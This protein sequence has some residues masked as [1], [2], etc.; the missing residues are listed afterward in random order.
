MNHDSPR[1]V[2]E[3][4]ASRGLNLSKRYGQNFLISRAAK[5]KLCA[6]LDLSAVHS[7][8]EVGPGLG[9]M[10]SLFVGRVDRVTVFEIDRGFVSALEELFEGVPG[11]RVVSGDVLKNW[12]RVLETDGIPDRIFGNLPYNCASAIIADFIESDVLPQRMVFTIQKE[13]ADRMVAQPGRATYSSF[14]V[15][16]QTYCTVRSHGDLSPGNFYPQPKV[17]SSIVELVPRKS[18]GVKDRS[19]LSTLVRELFSSR[20]KTVKNNLSRGKLSEQYGIQTLINALEACRIDPSSRAET[21]PV[22]VIIQ[23]ANLLSEESRL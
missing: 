21:L 16:C 17:T 13:V 10:T 12:K 11:L 15:L 18:P 6:V 22:E 19:L 1:E 14:S 3:F 9:A 20:R 8:W 4:L 5:E 7:L 23:Y 2:A